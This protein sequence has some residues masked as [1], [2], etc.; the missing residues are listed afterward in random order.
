MLS[1]PDALQMV[2]DTVNPLPPISLPL[3]K[4][5]GRVLAEPARACWDQPPADNSA[6]DGYA[7]TSLQLPDDLHLKLA[8]EAFAGHPFYGRIAPGEASRITT[9]ATLPV[10]CD[11]IVPIEETRLDGERVILNKPP[12]PGQH[13]RRRGEEFS[14]GEILLEPGSLLRS[15]AIGLLA[16]AGVEQLRVHPRPRVAILSTGDELVE[17]G[18]IPGPGQ[19]VNSNLHLLTARLRELDCEPLPIGIGRDTPEALVEAWQSGL[20]CDLLVST[21]GVSIGERDYVQA[22]LQR[23]GFTRKFWKVAIKPGKPVLFGTLGTTPVFGLPGNPA[24]TA[25]TCELFVRPA[26]RRLAGHRQAQPTEIRVRLAA[27]VE[28]DRHRLT[29]I[30]GNLELQADEL[31]FHPSQRQESGQN[32]SHQGAQALLPVAPELGRLPGGSC[33]RAILLESLV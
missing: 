28:P 26:L 8:G 11:C 9:G 22:S 15:G 17:L 1:Y 21:G 32:R 16:S 12:K 4:C 2:L 30:W 14:A 20:Q 19:I 10:G 29:F 3:D 27:A 7:L 33:A 24:A 13:I 5:L 31:L 6:M 25:A 23:L 18:E